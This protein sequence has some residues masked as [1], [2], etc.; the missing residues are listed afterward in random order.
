MAEDLQKSRLEIA[1]VVP[2][3]K[4]GL[5][6]HCFYSVFKINGQRTVKSYHTAER[7]LIGL[8]FFH[9]REGGGGML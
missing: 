7:D 2:M 5:V 6:L 9:R 1:A 3:A 4:C 8:S